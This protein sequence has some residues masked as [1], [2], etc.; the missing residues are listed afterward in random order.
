MIYEST[1]ELFYRN[2]VSI[3]V[4]IP[5]VDQS[6]DPLCRSKWRSQ[7]SIKVTIPSVDQS[8]DP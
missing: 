4:T 1:Y 8:D 6:D 5:S 7:V 2:L 3:K